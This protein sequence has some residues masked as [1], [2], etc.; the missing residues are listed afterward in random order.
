VPRF[1]IT[2]LAALLLVMG[3]SRG[4]TYELRGQ[5]LSVDAGRQELTIR[6]EDIRGFMPGMTMPF[7]V[8][9]KK[10][11][12]GRVPGD[13]V[14][15]TLVVHETD[16]FL[17]A[18]ERTGHAAVA[19]PVPRAASPGLGIGDE[20]P[21]VGFVDQSGT[22]RRLSDW[23]GRVVAVTFIYTRCPLPNFCPLMD[24][25]FAAVQ[26][27]IREDPRLR[28]G[29]HLVSVSFDPRFDTPT[30]LAA[31]A[32]RFGADPSTW[33]FMTGEQDAIDRFA[34]AFGVSIIRDD[35]GVE[36]IV[37]NLRTAVINPNGRLEQVFTGN[38]W[39]PDEL[40]A[41]MRRAGE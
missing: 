2:I 24:R 37:H 36:E 32:K 40:L 18:V 13:L 29:A 26:T 35:A 4:R 23:R 6:H 12:E 15:A 5:V 7:K 41:A 25:H 20:V 33:S 31:H 34:G 1:L 28:D 11:L 3:C 9:D 14:T 27:S 16:A 30:V 39:T 22:T 10:L 19:G 8:R 38:E 21:D 17:S